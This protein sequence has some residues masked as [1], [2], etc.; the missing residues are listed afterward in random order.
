MEFRIR[1][2][3][4]VSL[5]LICS[6]ALARPESATS[7]KPVPAAEVNDVNSIALPYIAEITGH[8]VHIRSG[9]GT[10]YYSC[11]KVKTGDRVTVVG[12]KF[13][14]SQIVPPA[15]SFSWIAQQY[16]AIDLNNPDYGT[17][18]G[19]DVRVYAGSDYKEPIHSTIMQQKLD[20]GYKIRLLGE[21]KDDYY[22]IAP[23]KGAYLWVSTQ[24]TK[25]IEP[26]KIEIEQIQPEPAPEVNIPKVVPTTISVEAKMLKEYGDLQKQ[27][28]A[29]R[30]K[31]VEKQ[32]YSEIKKALSKITA[33]KEAGKAARYSD[34][35]LKKIRRFE[36]ALAAKEKVESQEIQLKKITEQ[37]ENAR[38]KKL[39]HVEDMGKFAVIGEFQLSQIYSME[40]GPKH[41]RVLDAS[42]NTL[43]YALPSGSAEQANLDRFVG[44]K[45]GLVGEIEPYP[46]TSGALVRFVE[47]I[48]LK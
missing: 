33:N 4:L 5:S 40:Q 28:E 3:I 24:Y 38:Q 8:D 29:E 26:A 42:G 13:S 15:G 18:A 9:P 32:T 2:F 21:E 17:V 12:T 22:K 6:L 44:A 14:W 46:Q 19:D 37:I 39:A 23:P 47:V 31:P 45:V 25:A 10:N 7:E 41:Y 20:K 27:V 35:L 34:Y 48:E 16:V 11:G 43:C 1:T 30:A 36:L